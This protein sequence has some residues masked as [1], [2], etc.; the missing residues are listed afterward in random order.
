MGTVLLTYGLVASIVIVITVFS[1]KLLVSR[2]GPSL[3]MRSPQKRVAL[4]AI[5]LIIVGL[6]LASGIAEQVKSSPDAKT[7]GQRFNNNLD[8]SS[9]KGTKKVVYIDPPMISSETLLVDKDT[10]VVICSGGYV[11]SNQVVRPANWRGQF[12]MLNP[13]CRSISDQAENIERSVARQ[14]DVTKAQYKHLAA[15][16]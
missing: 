12:A 11:G 14:W 1:Y 15:N 8:T 4:L 10:I 13:V 9:E 3:T 7:I 5:S 2:Y 6:L 16:L